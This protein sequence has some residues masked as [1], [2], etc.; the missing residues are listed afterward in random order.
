M[1]QGERVM[2]RAIE[3]DDLPHVWEMRNDEETEALAFGVPTPHSMA[4]LEKS[5]ERNLADHKADSFVIEA[6]GDV[7]GRC[8]LFEVSDVDRTCR[9]GVTVAR[10]HR[11]KGYGSDAVRVLLA[12]AFRHRNLRKVCL[13]VLASNERAIRAYLACGF[14]Q[15][16]RLR[17]QSWY[18]GRYDD[19]VVMGVLRDE[20]EHAAT[21]GTST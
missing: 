11:G 9:I 8:V 15:E 5:Y 1:L 12:Y 17:E 13:D 21:S 3:R 10:D 2:L 20:W 16:G 6:A 18:D 4:E 19:L 7:V 14:V